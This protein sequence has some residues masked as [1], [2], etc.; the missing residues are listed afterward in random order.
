[1]TAH[2]G[3]T[4]KVIQNKRYGDYRVAQFINGV[5]ENEFDN[6]WTK[7]EADSAKQHMENTNHLEFFGL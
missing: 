4:Y 1:M 6:N 5:W 2:T 3:I 7:G